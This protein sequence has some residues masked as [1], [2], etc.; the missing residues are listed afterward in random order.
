VFDSVLL[1]G[2]AGYMNPADAIGAI[3]LFRVL[4]YLAPAVLAGVVFV[5]HEVWVTAAAKRV[6]TAALKD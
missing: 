3:L 2:L 6:L 5:G 1:L 4:Y